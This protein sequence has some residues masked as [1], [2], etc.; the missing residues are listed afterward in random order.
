MSSEAEK[1]HD[2]LETACNIKLDLPTFRRSFFRALHRSLTKDPEDFSA[3]I[4][5]EIWALRA[6]GQQLDATDVE[7]AIERVKSRLAREVRKWR[8]AHSPMYGQQRANDVRAAPEI[9]QRLEASNELAKAL[10]G[11]VE[12]LD[13]KESLIF[14]QCILGGKSLRLFCEETRMPKST[15]YRMRD[16]LRRRLI[17]SLRLS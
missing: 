4:F 8:S 1:L 15:T 7:R 5:A 12:T 17:A 10:H 3:L 2:I 13:A 11:F 9:L 14:D 16:A 6:D